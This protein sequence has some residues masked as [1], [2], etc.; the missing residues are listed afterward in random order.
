MTNAC[1]D[2]REERSAAVRII[3]LR[4]YKTSV[5][6]TGAWVACCVVR[7]GTR[8]IGNEPTICRAIGW[9][10]DWFRGA[11]GGLLVGFFCMALR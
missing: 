3:C 5:P 7:L 4:T 8:A 1:N 2:T 6:V 10:V 11:R 9:L